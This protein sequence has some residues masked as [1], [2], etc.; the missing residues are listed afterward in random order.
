MM[1]QMVE[2]TMMMNQIRPN[3]LK[4]A[5]LSSFFKMHKFDNEGIKPK[6]RM[7]DSHYD[8]IIKDLYGYYTTQQLHRIRKRPS[9]EHM[10]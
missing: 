3:S 6:K 1:K 9:Y 5:V 10:I 4:I 8:N 7:E 2:I